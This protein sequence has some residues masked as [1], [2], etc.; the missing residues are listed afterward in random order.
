[1]LHKDKESS[2]ELNN[3][4]LSKGYFLIKIWNVFIKFSFYSLEITHSTGNSSFLWK[5]LYNNSIVS[6][7]RTGRAG[8]NLQNSWD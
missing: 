8:K 4:S 2:V 7:N 1:M 3:K 6:L 5:H